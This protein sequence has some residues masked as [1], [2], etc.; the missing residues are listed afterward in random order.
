MLYYS[1]S[2]QN[3]NSFY[4]KARACCFARFLKVED[5]T[6]TLPQLKV[7]FDAVMY[8]AYVLSRNVIDVTYCKLLSVSLN[9]SPPAYVLHQY[10]YNN[11]KVS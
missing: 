8:L 7:C 5:P 4:T 3:K 6:L 9:I 1:I 11:F 2:N 10:L